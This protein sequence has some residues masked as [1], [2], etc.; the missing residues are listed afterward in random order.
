MQVQ[1]SAEPI[2]KLLGV[3]GD[4]SAQLNDKIVKANKELSPEGVWPAWTEKRRQ[5]E[6]SVNDAIQ[7][8]EDL[9]TVYAPGQP[10]QSIENAQQTLS[11]LPQSLAELERAREMI[12][13]TLHWLN[14]STDMKQNKR[15]ANAKQMK[16]L[17]K[18]LDDKATDL[19]EL[20]G[21]LFK[22]HSIKIH[23]SQTYRRR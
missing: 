5:V 11:E 2:D 23:F 9:R 21:E 22:K 4:L 6:T 16:K 3:I 15:E 19:S 10:P 12:F 18:K 13:D 17:L 14:G 1:T 7:H 20:E 8:A